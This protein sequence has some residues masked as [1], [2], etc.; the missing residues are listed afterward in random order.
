MKTRKPRAAEET[1]S[2]QAQQ[3]ALSLQLKALKKTRSIGVDALLTFTSYWRTEAKD[4]SRQ[5]A[6]VQQENEQLRAQ[7]QAQKQV[8]LRLVNL[9]KRRPSSRVRPFTNEQH[10]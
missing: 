9:M 3:L 1:V 5:R 2:L 8:A 7:L 10:V 4:L 6:E